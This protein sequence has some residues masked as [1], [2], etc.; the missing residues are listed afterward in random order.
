MTTIRRVYILLVC[1]VSLQATTW[2][3]I[4]LL[5]GLLQFDGRDPIAAVA[6]QIAVIVI[7]LPIF[8]GH[9]IWA[10][11]LA[12]ADLEERGSAVRRL[13]LYGTLAALLG[14]GLVNAVG[15]IQAVLVLISGDSTFDRSTYSATERIVRSL[16]AM[17]VLGLLWWYHQ[18]I[19]MA[20]A[21]AVPETDISASLHRLYRFGFSTVGMI[22]VASAA[23]SMLHWILFQIG[24]S[25]SSGSTQSL[26]NDLAIIAVGLPLWLICWNQAQRLFNAAIQ[27]EQ[28]STLRKI[29]L[30]ATVFV[31]VLSAVSNATLLLAGLLQRLLGLSPEGD[32]RGPLVIIVTAGV[33][34]AYH[35][36]VL[37][38]DAAQA[39][40]APDQ[41]GVQRLYRYLVAAIGLAAA[42]IGGGGVFSVLIRA[43]AEGGFSDLLSEQLAWF[44]AALIT[45]TPVWFLPWRQV[46]AVAA[47]PASAG[48][49][50]RRS[51]VRKLYLYAYLFLSTMVVLGGA[52]YIVTRLVR[53]LLGEALEGNLLSDL[54]QAL[55]FT[56]LGI[57][58][59]LYHGAGLRDD[60][61]AEQRDRVERL[62]AMRVAVVDPGE[63]SFGRSIIEGLHQEL[64]GLKLELI[65][66]AAGASTS[67]QLAEAGLIIGPWTIAAGGP[68]GLPPELLRLIT[69]SPARKLLVPVQSSTWEWIGVDNTDTSAQVRQAVQAVRRIGEGESVG[70][71]GSFS[72]GA[73]IAIIIGIIVVVP[74]LLSLISLVLGNLFF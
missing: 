3:G 56:A 69:T 7:G 65:T 72:A 14:P 23:T 8:A 57:A 50:E 34:W 4:S 55:A 20:D 41:A 13:Y 48:A 17:V 28:E 2:A 37:Q 44:S 49:V 16:V 27:A 45:G 66:P 19:A 42:L 39:P 47:A 67:G 18:R 38:A 63:G 73:I 43:A 11:R 36:R 53:L 21:Q 5:R 12:A 29:Y 15:L 22:M 25:M 68:S 61:R 52:V 46:S 40:E 32:A 30:Y 54:G 26:T 6:F 64:P 62:A 70:S 58:T 10:E 35:A 74:I 9:W 24:P 33:L 1:A 60:G 51:F 31:T 59:W 71:T